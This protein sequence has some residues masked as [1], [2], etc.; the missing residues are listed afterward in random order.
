M[1]VRLST[2][3]SRDHPHEPLLGGRAADAAFYPTPLI[4]EI[5]RGMRDTADAEAPAEDLAPPD[6]QHA[7]TAMGLCHDVPAGIRAAVAAEDLADAHRK[8]FTKFRMHDG[9]VHTVPLHKH[10]KN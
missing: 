10:F 6:L 8:R 4:T 5:L 3:C 1:A 2:R 7:S 9:S